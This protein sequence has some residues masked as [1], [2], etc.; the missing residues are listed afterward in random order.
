MDKVIEFKKIEKEDIFKT[1]FLNMAKNNILSFKKGNTAILYGP[2]GTGKTSLSKIFSL[3][4]KTDIM[5]K[6]ENIDYTKELIKQN[7]I[8]YVISDQNSRNIVRGKEEDFLVGT[9][10]KREYELKQ[11][12]F[13]DENSLVDS[14]N[15]NVREMF[16]L[17]KVTDQLIIEC[18]SYNKL[19][20][21]VLRELCKARGKVNLNT[22][23]FINQFSK[24]EE[25]KI[26]EY[27]EEKYEYLKKNYN[28]KILKEIEKLD[29]K[30]IQKKEKIKEINENEDAIKILEKYSY[31][32]CECIICE[33]EIEREKIL[34]KK[35]LN[36]EKITKKLSPLAKE[37]L[38][39]ILKKIGSSSD[40]FELKISIEKALEEGEGRYILEIQEEIKKYKKIFYKK[41]FN[42][43]LEKVKDSDL[44]EKYEEYDELKSKNPE[45]TDEDFLLVTTLILENIGKKIEFTRVDNN[46]K[47]VLKL[48]E[49]NLL[50]VKREELYLSTGEQ[51]FISIAFELLQAKNKKEKIVV[52]DDPISSFDS[53]YKNKIIFLLKKLM[54]DKK[55]IL[56]THNLDLVKLM[57]YQQNNTY[58]MYIFNN[59]DGEEN[60]FIPVC[61]KERKLLLKIK[62]LLEL[63]SKDI[64]LEVEDEKIFLMSLIPFMRGYSQIIYEETIENEL[65][66]LMHGY[67]NSFVNLTN[68]YIKLFLNKNGK[69]NRNLIKNIYNI[70]VN[71]ILSIDLDN[72]KILKDTTEYALLNRTLRHSLTYLFL[73]L[74]TEKKLVDKYK[75]TINKKV[76]MLSHIIMKA[77]P[78]TSDLTIEN[79]LTN[80][81]FFLSRKTLLNDFNHFEGNLSIFQPAID[82]TD[83][84]LEK[85]KISIL[86]KLRSL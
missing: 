44:L 39:K 56:L 27:E 7:N 43:L 1:N 48:G 38:E 81:V 34:E 69:V 53:I 31:K 37:I 77:F 51:N 24:L 18:D 14:C 28:E 64:F 9:D 36:L 25:I 40:P 4:D 15:L 80:R 11:R 82:I 57:E 62:D 35:S 74:S 42:Q 67:N 78:Q 70:S 66:K 29:I 79:N 41:I 3:E 76:Y 85:E 13:Q 58:S 26:E 12:I 17:T 32:T 33:S 61:E 49:Q 46:T 59:I 50:G 55:Q 86:D 6:F 5:F 23:D 54:Q 45:I 8:F 22:R 20:Y 72:V 10:I 19:L 65:T 21:S 60:G 52:I 2:N 73:R 83:I 68:I 63:L 75:I 16:L 30:R 71:D 84:A 47:I